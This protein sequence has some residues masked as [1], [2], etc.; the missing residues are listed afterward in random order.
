MKV[1]FNKTVDLFG[2]CIRFRLIK[3]KDVI[4][5]PAIGYNIADKEAIVA[6]PFFVLYILFRP[7]NN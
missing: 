7:D 2:V 1:I 3:D 5:T 6:V 4:V